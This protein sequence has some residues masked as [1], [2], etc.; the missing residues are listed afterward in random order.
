MCAKL[1]ALAVAVLGGFPALAQVAGHDTPACTAMDASLPD[2]MADWN[3]KAAMET[4]T[5][6][7]EMG[8]ASLQL[9]RGYEVTLKK[10]A[11][12]AFS[13]EPEKPGGSVS[14]SGLFAFDVQAAGNYAVALG[15]PPWIDVLEDGKALEPASF[16]HGPACTTIRKNVVYALKSGP[17]ILQ[18]AGNGAEALKLM[19]TKLP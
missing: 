8:H 18:V 7:T 3:G 1:T 9:G 19:I 4:A 15:A 13:A 10:K 2:G 12:V 16:G 11:D 17:H 14:Y 5:S 6:G